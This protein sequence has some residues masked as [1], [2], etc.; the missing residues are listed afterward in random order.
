MTE[1]GPEG[2][3][4]SLCGYLPDCAGNAAWNRAS[5]ERKL[6]GIEDGWCHTCCLP[7]PEELERLEAEAGRRLRSAP[8]LDLE[9]TELASALD[10]LA[11]VTAIVTEIGGYMTPEQQET[12]ARA[13]ARLRESGRMASVQDREKR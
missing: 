5:A 7:N 11:E 2:C 8:P 10:D 3:G 13:R 1:H 9:S 4:D 12:M 6:Q